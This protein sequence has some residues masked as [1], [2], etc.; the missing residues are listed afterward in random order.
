[1][2]EVAPD[3]SLHVEGEECPLNYVRAKLGLERLGEG[4]VLEVFVSG[5]E[6]ARNVPRSVREEG[7]E[8]LAVEPAG[9]DRVRVLIRKREGCR[10]A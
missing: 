2:E 7:H 5:G 9:G 4:R 10:G 1:M 3:L 6:A 8:V